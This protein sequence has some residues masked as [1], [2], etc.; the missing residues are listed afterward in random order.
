MK[1]NDA[2]EDLIIDDKSAKR[3][4]VEEAMDMGQGDDRLSGTDRKL[5]DVT[6]VLPILMVGLKSASYKTKRSECTLT[7]A[8]I[9]M[10]ILSLCGE[11]T[12]KDF[13]PSSM[14]HEKRSVQWNTTN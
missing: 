11:S 4:R 13:K 8:T 10:E 5:T 2:I 14:N 6:M 1:R 3:K 9:E 7:E 12:R